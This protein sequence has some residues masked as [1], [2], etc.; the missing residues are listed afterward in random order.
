MR[1]GSERFFALCLAVGIVIANS[2]TA[3]TDMLPACTPAHAK[4]LLASM[5]HVLQLDDPQAYKESLPQR[6]TAAL[7][8]DA[9]LI[10]GFTSANDAYRAGDYQTT[11]LILRKMADEELF[12]IE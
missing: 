6:S 3:Q 4:N 5:A 7:L 11:C 9:Q 2:A 10:G 12:L 8:H 1:T